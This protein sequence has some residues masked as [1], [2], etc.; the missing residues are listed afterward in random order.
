MKHTIH[1]NH[2]NRLAMI[3]MTRASYEKEWTVWAHGKQVS[4]SQDRSLRPQVSVRRRDGIRRLRN[5]AGNK[6]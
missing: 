3:S 6:A 5:W 4:Q 1:L 2:T